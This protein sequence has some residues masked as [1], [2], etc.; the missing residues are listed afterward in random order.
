MHK[1]QLRLYL[2]QLDRGAGLGRRGQD[3]EG[4][5][6]T[7]NPIYFNSWIFTTNECIHLLTM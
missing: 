7:L 4:E 3:R 1:K 6:L 5:T 2:H